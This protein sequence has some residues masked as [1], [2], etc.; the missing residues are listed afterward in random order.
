M[1]QAYNLS[2]REKQVTE[3]LLQ[4]KSN[5]QIALALGISENT[6]EFH[7]KN[8]YA[9]LKV[10]S[11][12]EAILK[13]GKSTGSIGENLRESVVERTSENSHTGGISI[14]T[15]DAEMKNR[16][17]Y[18]FLAGLIFG[19]AYWHYFSVTARFLNN[20]FMDVE[21]NALMIW[22]VLS[23]SFLIYFGVW[24][25]P[26]ILPAVYEFRRSRMMS[27]S[28]L[29]VVVVWSS[30][31]LGYYINYA[32]LLAFVGL[33]NMEY[34]L[35]FGQHGPTFWQDWGDLF[36]KLILYNFLKWTAVGVFISGFAGLVTS[37]L[38]SLLVK[39]PDSV[40]RA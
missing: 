4:G 13:L 37:S 10:G 39:K 8:V 20:I 34:Y 36:P 16:W 29:A 19:A 24:L 18:Y 33:P 17:S 21:E 25:I 40:M 12:A 2:K 6:V 14:L 26:A 38:Y 32:V 11:R 30:A 9:K 35:V 31:V 7:L 28:V 3:C 15:K 22:M 23:V 1:M 5:K 27:L